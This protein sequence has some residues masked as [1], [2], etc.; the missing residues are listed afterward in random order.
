N[1]VKE[2]KPK[3]MVAAW[4]DSD[5]SSS[6]TEDVQKK[7]DV[8]WGPMALEKETLEVFLSA[9]I[10]TAVHDATPE[11]ALA[12]VF[13]A[14][15]RPIAIGFL[16]WCLF[17]LRWYH[18]G[19]GGRDSTHVVS[20]VSVAPVGVSAY[21]LGG[22]LRC[23]GPPSSGAFEGAFGAT[24]VLE[25]AA[26]L[27]DSRVEGKTR[28]VSPSSDCLALRWFQSCVGR[29]GAEAGARLAS[30]GHG[31]LV[32][33]LA[34]SDGGLVAVVV[35][36][37]PHD[38]CAS[39]GF[40]SVSSQFRSPVLGFHSVVAPTCAQGCFRFV[41]YSVGFC[42]GRVCVT[43]L[44]GGRDVAMFWIGN[45]YWALFA[46]LTPYFLQG[47]SLRELGVGR[48]A[49]A[50][51]QVLGSALLLGLSRCSVCQVALL[52]ER[53]DTCLWLFV[54]LVLAGCELWLRCIAWLPCV[55]GLRYPVDLAGVFW[56]IFL[57]RC[58]SGSGGGSPRTGLHSV[59]CFSMLPSPVWCLWLVG[60]PGMEHL[61]EVVSVAW[62]PHPREPL[63]ERSGLRACLS[64]QPSWRTL[65]LRGKRGL[66]S[67][68]ESFV[69]PSW[70]VW[71]VEAG[72]SSSR[73]R[74]VNPS[75]HCLALCWFR[76]R[77]GWSDAD[78]G[79]RLVSR[80]RGRRVPLLAASSGGLVAVVVT[81]FPH[82]VSMYDS[83]P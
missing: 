69:E 73:R 16:S 61:V 5:E 66:D 39:G 72:W 20:G 33:L 22:C 50:A 57:E 55:L 63:R 26:E 54:G 29:S 32:P 78:A 17:P 80:G 9:G 74:P 27:A 46:R 49:E 36:V 79:A 60:G 68:A 38:T 48:V 58:L 34:A 44:V 77:V 11:E 65:E 7:Q 67:G 62:D 42:G 82:N 81:V 18:D 31:R 6:A 43:N 13:V 70:L 1:K 40:C 76:C 3:A 25:L 56:R 59:Y 51:L 8:V 2:K 37:F 15:L 30:R 10:A 52:V 41:P 75:S 47:S 71:D 24:S 19:L 53:C 21:A 83:L 4:S 28:P 12:R 64:W 35:T 23:L 45:P 14:T